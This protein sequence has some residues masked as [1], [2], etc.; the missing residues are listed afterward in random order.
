MSD[1][2]KIK[3][4]I[5]IETIFIR[6]VPSNVTRAMLKSLDMSVSVPSSFDYVWIYLL[7]IEV[8]VIVLE[9]YPQWYGKVRP[10]TN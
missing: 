6:I 7:E 1:F 8:G 10:L 2:D 9:Y 5:I 3:D 4:R